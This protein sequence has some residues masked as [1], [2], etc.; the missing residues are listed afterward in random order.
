M[1]NDITQE[2][3]EI[4]NKI[5]KHLRSIFRDDTEKLWENT[6]IK[7]QM[8]KRIRGEIFTLSNHIQAMVY[9]MLSSGTVWNRIFREA[10][11]ETAYINPV[12]KIFCDY[13]PAELLKSSPEQLRDELKK[14]HCAS[15]YTLKQMNA[16]ISVNIPK[17]LTIEKEHGTIDNY[18]GGFIQSDE[19]LLT[20]VKT[21]SNTASK[22][23]MVQMDIA[24]VCEYLRNIGY[25]VPKPDRHIRRI[26]GSEIL[27][28]SHSKI[29]PPFQTFEIISK[30]A[31]LLNKPVAE[32]DYILWSYC[33]TGYGEI[34]TSTNPKCELCVVKKYCQHSYLEKDTDKSIHKYLLYSHYGIKENDTCSEIIVRAA[35]K[36][37]LDFCRRVSFE[38]N[39]PMN[40][41]K[42]FELEV[43]KLLSNMI[44]SLL[45]VTMNGEES[46]QLF[47]KKHNEIC[48][49]IISVYSS[50]GGQSYGVAQKWLNQTLMN[51][52]VINSNLETNFPLIIE[53]RKYFHIPIDQYLLE[54]ATTRYTD[55]FQ[56]GLNLKCAPLKH[57]K[58]DSYQMDWFC[59]GKTQP[60]EYWEYPEY[61]EFQSAVKRKIKESTMT[62]NY[63]DSLDWTFNAFLEVSQAR[64]H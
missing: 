1:D 29:V 64:N 56:H 21:L 8:D 3:A 33:S 15:Q 38:K 57:D 22:D 60:F 58:A 39:V 20:L 2:R 59:P 14:I 53:A 50:V 25:D 27:S 62:Y 42:T 9:S 19:T 11:T 31:K 16:L 24:L 43:E 52:V 63:S 45:E 7:R 48:E 6:F 51:L 28:F 13:H 55:R 46:Q 61:I 18:Y 44:P 36:S 40:D 47:N 34:C 37:Y 41:R 5:D 10:D 32:V 12:D 54:V 49:L 35:K 4:I 26:L 23:K 17:L 30:L